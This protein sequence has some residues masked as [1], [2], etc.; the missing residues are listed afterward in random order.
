MDAI[1]WILGTLGAFG[2]WLLWAFLGNDV[3]EVLWLLATPLR[4]AL[5][6][7]L[8]NARWPWP[9]LLLIGIGTSLFSLGL[10][11]MARS[12]AAPWKGAAGL[13]LFF[14]GAAVGLMSPLLWRDAR[15]ARGY[16]GNAPEPRAKR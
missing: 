14:V 2:L 12:A 15:R 1:H 9:L 16:G 7:V 6:H 4:R 3:A 5:W 8:V 13:V 10:A 11:L